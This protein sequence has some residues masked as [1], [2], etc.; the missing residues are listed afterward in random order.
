MFN[1]IKHSILKLFRNDIYH[2]ISHK[3]Y[4]YNYNSRDLPRL[5]PF[6]IEHVKLDNVT[7]ITRREWVN[8]FPLGQIKDGE[9]DQT[10]KM[11]MWKNIGN[12]DKKKY[13]SQNHMGVEIK[14]TLFF[15]GCYEH[16]NEGVPWHETEYWN[17]AAELIQ[18]GNPI[19]NNITT[20]E[21]LQAD[22]HKTDSLY[23]SI[24]TE[25]YR[26]QQELTNKSFL[27]ARLHEVGLDIGRD[28]KLLFRSGQHR[29]FV[30]KCLGLETIPVV[31]H[32]RHEQ[33]MDY[34]KLFHQNDKKSNHPDLRNMC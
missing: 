9:W 29:L 27:D 20:I 31:F 3:Y 24:Q 2:R 17:T 34:R 15:Q 25:G 21:G 30:A 16:F 12:K 6:K 4:L 5:D 33:W 8:E 1:K 32:T 28:G 19:H 26:L 14:D 11:Q 23:Q 22:C 10:K 13:Y 7:E 18:N